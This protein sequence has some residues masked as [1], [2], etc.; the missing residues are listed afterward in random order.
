[1]L[2]LVQAAA[3]EHIAE[4]LFQRAVHD[5]VELQAG[6]ARQLLEHAGDGEI[7]DRVPHQVVLEAD[8][9]SKRVFIVEIASCH[10]RTEDQ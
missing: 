3:I 1:M 10:S 8:D 7:V 2:S 5:K 4:K 9:L 6:I